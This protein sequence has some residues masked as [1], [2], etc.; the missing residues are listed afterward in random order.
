[1][2]L[3]Q[4]QT[5]PL[6]ILQW[7]FIEP[8]T[9]VDLTI[10]LVLHLADQ[11]LNNQ[12]GEKICWILRMTHQCLFTVIINRSLVVKV[13]DDTAPLQTIAC[14]ALPFT[15][16][17]LPFAIDSS[18]KIVSL[19]YSYGTLRKPQCNQGDPLLLINHHTKIYLRVPLFI[20]TMQGMTM[21][22]LW[23]TRGMAM[24]RYGTITPV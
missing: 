22:H 23:Y 20:V 16:Y 15:V 11:W 10:P 12:I 14:F 13:P 4:P 17:L 21:A 5:R 9:L 8:E 24:V 3:Q 19:W 6:L 2:Y 7:W 1:M 18:C